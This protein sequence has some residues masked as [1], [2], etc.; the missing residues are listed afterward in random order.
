MKR[1]IATI[2]IISTA[3]LVTGCGDKT[4]LEIE[5]ITPPNILEEVNNSESILGESSENLENVTEI[6]LEDATT[7]VEAELPAEQGTEKETEKVT[8]KATEKVTEAVTQKAAEAA[9]SGTIASVP[10]WAAIEADVSLSGSGTG[11][12]AKLVICTPTSAVSYGIQYDACAAAPYTGKAMAMLEN[13][14]S[15]NAGGQA[16]SRPG[17]KELTLGETY[18]MMITLNQDGSGSVYLDNQKIGDYYNPA[19]AYQSIVYLRVEGSARKNGDG[20]NASFNNIKLKVDGNYNA[21]RRFGTY[22]FKQNATIN[23]SV[24]STSSIYISG[25]V[26]GISDA[27]DWD[28]RYNDVSGIIQFVQ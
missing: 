28:S 19:L 6:I 5:D 17:N 23:S 27:E 25:F 12:H 18:H 14:G 21:S 2:V 16:Y 24:Y 3:L 10:S 26:S 4:A 15:N 9:S 20:V 22:E 11:Y 8:E 1:K 13:I 7:V